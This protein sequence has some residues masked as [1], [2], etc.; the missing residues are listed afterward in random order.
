LSW[1]VGD[2]CGGRLKEDTGCQSACKKDPGS[3]TPAVDR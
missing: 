1:P 3:R 2:N